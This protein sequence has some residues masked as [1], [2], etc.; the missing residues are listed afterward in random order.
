MYLVRVGAG[1]L[2]QGQGQGQGWYEA[3]SCPICTR[4]EGCPLCSQVVSIGIGIGI[5]I[6]VLVVLLLLVLVFTR[7]QSLPIFK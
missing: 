3:Q 7:A 1:I 5:G 6:G 4:A 2:R